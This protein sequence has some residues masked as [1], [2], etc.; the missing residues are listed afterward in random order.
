MNLINKGNPLYGPA[1]LRCPRCHEGK[2]FK[3]PTFSY[4]KPFEMP[5][6]CSHCGLDYWPEPGF[7]YGAMFISYIF[8]GFFCISFVLALHWGLG[9]STGASFGAL[10]AICAI[11]FVYIFRLARA[12]WLS[13]NVRYNPNAVDHDTTSTSNRY[14]NS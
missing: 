10:I 11:F 5:E 14:G 9:W 2:L 4:S 13:I 7:Y 8:T 1:K 3:T 6:R 12:I